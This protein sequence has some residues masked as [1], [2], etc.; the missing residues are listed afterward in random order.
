MVMPGHIPGDMILLQQRSKVV[1]EALGGAVRAGRPNRVVPPDPQIIRSGGGE[2]VLQPLPLLCGLVGISRAVGPD[3][4][5]V[6]VVVGAEQNYGVDED[7]LEGCGG[8][9]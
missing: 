6:G 4:P 3:P 2:L 1:Y 7:D 8:A 5:A 9:G